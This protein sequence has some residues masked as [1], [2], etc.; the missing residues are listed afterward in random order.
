MV[1]ILTVDICNR[2][3]GHSENTR[4]NSCLGTQS[5]KTE[6]VTQTGRSAVFLEPVS[7]DEMLHNKWT[8]FGFSLQNVLLKARKCHLSATKAFVAFNV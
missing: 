7:S 8:V 3:S 6:S 5:V 2:V 1:D 4:H